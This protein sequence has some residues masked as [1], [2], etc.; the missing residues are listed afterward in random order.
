MEEP[1]CR[2]LVAPMRFLLLSPEGGREKTGAR[3]SITNRG[4]RQR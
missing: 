3:C 1:A 4:A 2:L